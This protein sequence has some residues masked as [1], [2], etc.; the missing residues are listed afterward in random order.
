MEQFLEKD[1]SSCALSV[2]KKG[3]LSTSPCDSL[4]Y[5][6]GSRTRGEFIRPDISKINR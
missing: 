4:F 3:C 6:T 1:K 2:A 5:F